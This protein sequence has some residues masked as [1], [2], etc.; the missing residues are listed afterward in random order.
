M[1]SRVCEP[2]PK[3]AGSQARPLRA[4]HLI[5]GGVPGNLG[6]MRQP[7]VRMPEHGHT[8][9]WQSLEVESLVLDHGLGN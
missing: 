8:T 4:A 2:L 1:S 3:T 5:L 6:I 9:H 7:L